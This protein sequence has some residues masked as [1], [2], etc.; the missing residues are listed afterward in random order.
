MH[1]TT[2]QI[3]GNNEAEIKRIRVVNSP[4][5]RQVQKAAERNQKQVIAELNQINKYKITVHDSGIFL[6]FSSN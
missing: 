3:G 4:R 5:L 2:D 1:Y 6:T